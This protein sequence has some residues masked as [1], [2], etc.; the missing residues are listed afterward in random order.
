MRNANLYRDQ[1]ASKAQR[2]RAKGLPR[3]LTESLESLTDC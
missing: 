1:A 2:A 3:W